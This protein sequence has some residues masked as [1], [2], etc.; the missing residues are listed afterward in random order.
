MIEKEY[1]YY[2]R[3]CLLHFIQNEFNSSSTRILC[4]QILLM[5]YSENVEEI[6]LSISEN[7][8][9]EYN[10]R[11]DATDVVLR[12]GKDNYK[13]I[14]KNIIL[15]LVVFYCT[16]T[17]IPILWIFI[18]SYNKLL[19]LNAT[20]IL[21][22]VCICIMRIYYFLLLI[23]NNIILWNNLPRILNSSKILILYLIK[24]IA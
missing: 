24:C 17:I 15:E 20:C 2:E 23:Y 22:I 3:V 8:K 4:G 9:E 14:A 11:A 19:I 6:L 13:S 16:E 1:V 18:P 5:K 12:Y 10:V 7:T 21:I